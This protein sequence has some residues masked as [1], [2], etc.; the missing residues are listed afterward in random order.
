MSP[1]IAHRNYIEIS[2]GVKCLSINY[3]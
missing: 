2:S 1:F 3:M